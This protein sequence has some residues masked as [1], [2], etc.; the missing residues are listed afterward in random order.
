MPN[1]DSPTI[2]TRI[3]TFPATESALAVILERLF[4][5]WISGV[6][7]LTFIGALLLAILGVIGWM[8]LIYV[9]AGVTIITLVLAGLLYLA[10]RD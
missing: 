1:W 10:R 6:A 7:A 5:V 8:Q 9:Y 3:L 4:F 2:K